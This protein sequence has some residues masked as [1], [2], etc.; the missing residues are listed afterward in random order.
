MIRSHHQPQCFDLEETSFIHSVTSSVTENRPAL[1]H[2]PCSS[3]P[4]RTPRCRTR[5][6]FKKA[7]SS[8]F[9]QSYII[10]SPSLS[11][12]PRT[13]LNYQ[14]PEA[15][16]DGRVG[17]EADIWALGCAIFEIRA[18]LCPLRIVLGKRRRHSQ[19]NG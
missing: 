5:R 6:F 4:S 18:G 14:S 16:F 19:A 17:F 9:G 13:A 11:Y 3:R 15:R 8:D 12:E 10:A 1:T 7:L 2:Q